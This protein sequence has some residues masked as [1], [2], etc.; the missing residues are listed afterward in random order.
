M[1]AGRGDSSFTITKLKTRTLNWHHI[2]C[3]TGETTSQLHYTSLP[4]ASPYLDML[5]MSPWMLTW[6]EFPMIQSVRYST[7][8]LRNFI[9]CLNVKSSLLNIILNKAVKLFYWLQ[10]LFTLTCFP[11]EGSVLEQYTQNLIFLWFLINL[12]FLQFFNNTITYKFTFHVF[13]SMNITVNSSYNKP[14]GTLKKCSL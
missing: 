14:R 1:C 7:N 11:M 13:H 3:D 6:W 8:L 5:Q 4:V 2:R 9:S 12:N 10:Y